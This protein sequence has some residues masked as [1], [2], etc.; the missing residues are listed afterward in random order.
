M[1]SIIKN[2][3]KEVEKNKKEFSFL[4]NVKKKRKKRRTVREQLFFKRAAYV[5]AI[6]EINYT[7]LHFPLELAILA[8]IDFS[9]IKRGSGR[10]V[11]KV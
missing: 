1:I 2:S 7:F 4:F 9:R 5:F 8:Y 6:T 3:M 10:R 11:N